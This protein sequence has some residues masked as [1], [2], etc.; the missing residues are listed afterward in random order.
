MIQRDGWTRLGSFTYHYCR[1]DSVSSCGRYQAVCGVKG[2]IEDLVPIANAL[3][4]C[5]NCVRA[6]DQ[7]QF[8]ASADVPLERSSGLPPNQLKAKRWPVLHLGSVPLDVPNS[9][10][11]DGAVTH[12]LDLT[13]EALSALAQAD[14][15]AD[16]HCIMRWTVSGIKWRGVAMQTIIEQVQPT[17]RFVLAHG[18]NDYFTNLSVEDATQGLVALEAGGKPL[19][20][21][22]G[23]PIRLVI[24]HLYAW[25]SV[26]WLNRLEFV[27][28]DEAGTW[29]QRGLHNRGD[30]WAEERFAKKPSG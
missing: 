11:V 15:A 26:K 25:K 19:E 16:M 29:E 18:A 12:S 28:V 3:P 8:D 17:G 2:W 4:W 7:K 14:L 21:E 6:L 24:P 22:H 23:G 27:E 9:L 10:C 20:P 1:L 30:V 5:N 13:F